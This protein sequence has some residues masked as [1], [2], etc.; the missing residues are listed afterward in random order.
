MSGRRVG[1]EGGGQAGR[2]GG[3][4]EQCG[5]NGCGLPLKTRRGGGK[6]APVPLI[7]GGRDVF[8][9]EH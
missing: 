4:R 8:G 6:G 1:G 7:A 2:D 3:A 5:S 9:S